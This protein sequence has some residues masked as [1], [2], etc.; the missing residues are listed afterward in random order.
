ML[1]NCFT[2]SGACSFAYE[3]ASVP[4]KNGFGFEN[5]TVTVFESVAVTLCTEA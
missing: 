4:R 3:P 2:A 5:F 1:S